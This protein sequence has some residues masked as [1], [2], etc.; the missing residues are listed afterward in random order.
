[1]S[2]TSKSNVCP[3]TTVD[4]STITATNAPASLSLTW[5]T[6]ATAT[7]ANRIT[8]I[9]SLTAG[10]YYAAYFDATANCYSGTAT[11]PVTASVAACC[12]VS[13]ASGGLCSTLTP[14]ATGSAPLTYTWTGPTLAVT[15][16]T[17]DATHPYFGLGSS[18]GYAVNGVQGKQ[19]TLV[20]GVTY[21]FSVNTPGHPFVFTNSAVGGATNTGQVITTGVTNSGAISGNVTFTPSAATPNLI[22]YNCNV[23]D[24]M[25]YQINIIDPQANGVL[26]NAM[27]GSYSLMV[28]DATGCMATT[29]ATVSASCAPVC[30]ATVAPALSVTSKTNT[31]P[32]TTID[33]STITASNAPAG[34][35]LTWHTG[36]PAT[37]VNRITSITS[38][39]AGTY[40]AA[41]YDATNNCYSGANVTP[42][43]ASTVVCCT[44]GT[45]APN[46]STQTPKNICPATT[47][48]LSTITVSNMPASTT[49]TWHTSSPATATNRITA[50]TSVTAG[51]YYAAFYDPA[52]NCYSNFA[53]TPV[54][55]TTVACCQ[56]GTVA[57]ALSAT[58]KTNVCPATT[59]DL[60]TITATNTPAS[61]TLSWHTGTPATATNRITAITAVAPGTYYAAFFDATNNCFSGTG[62]AVTSVTAS[63]VACCP[64]PSVGG[65][66]TLVGTLPLCSVSNQGVLIVTGQTGTVV[67]WQTS[68]NGGTT[69]TDIPGTAGLT[70]YSFTNAQNNQLFR[71]VVN[72]GGSCSD[73]NSN[74]FATPTSA[75]A[76]SAD[77]DVKPGDIKK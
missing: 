54:F 20:R 44:L 77:C 48:D 61:T 17:K 67:K 50:I 64:N 58:S 2:A 72:A 29:T 51:I 52:A 31:C 65:S 15:T 11:T 69:F 60:S 22:Y 74:Q 35:T 73:A 4:L 32:A 53:T 28:M 59:I 8:N 56:S 47:V 9:T 38:L 25:G 24:Y 42:V 14:V 23:H 16:V 39:T 57:P 27:P 68:T 12:S 62:T 75:S 37:A 21:T 19:L 55:A 6:S 13:M 5:H 18:M 30:S 7:A 63:V 26:V 33:L 41:F 10:T 45:V 36:T 66:L 71:A 49:L 70:Q 76:C 3:A 43:T 46:L 34:T 1:L 40:Y